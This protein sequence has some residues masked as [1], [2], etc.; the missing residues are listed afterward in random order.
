MDQI[1]IVI[2]TM[3]ASVVDTN[4]PTMLYIPNFLDRL[5]EETE[6]NLTFETTHKDLLLK[7]WITPGLSTEILSFFPTSEQRT[8]RFQD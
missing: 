8:G 1:S 6:D 2:P 5:V 4:P 3:A 7:D